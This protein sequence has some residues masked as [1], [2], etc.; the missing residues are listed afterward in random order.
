MVELK[1]A[2]DE[3]DEQIKNMKENIRALKQLI[4]YDQNTLNL[5]HKLLEL[6]LKPGAMQVK[7]PTFAYEETS[8]YA[9]WMVLKAQEE[10]AFK[11][12]TT[13]ASIKE[14]G[15][16]LEVMESELLKLQKGKGGE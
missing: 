2:V 5:G 12:S 3:A 15:K 14:A 9:D 6:Q 1:K 7:K 13:E 4:G 8:E 16:R 11:N 10:H